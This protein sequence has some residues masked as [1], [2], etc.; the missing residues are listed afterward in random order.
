[1]ISIALAFITVIVILSSVLSLR[2]Q[3]N[4]NASLDIVQREIRVVL[5]IVDAINHTRTARTWL[6]QA[7]LLQGDAAAATA[8]ANA[9]DKLALSKASMERYMHI[10]KTDAEAQLVQDF[11]KNYDIYLAQGL[12]PLVDALRQGDATTYDKVLRFKTPVL[13]RQFEKSLDMVLQ[14]RERQS[15][16]LNDDIKAAFS[17]DM[18]LLLILAVGY[19]MAM[20]V[21]W[22]FSAKALAQPLNEMA[23]ALKRFANK[24]F[25]HPA[26][27]LPS[28]APIEIHTMRSSL[29]SMQVELSKT[30]G[31]IRETADTV[32]I[33]AAEISQGTQDLAQRTEQQAHQLQSS[34]ATLHEMSDQIRATSSDA[35]GVLQA[36]R[37]AVE[38]ACE[39]EERVKRVVQTM[40]SIQDA[41]QRIGVIVSTIDSIAFQTNILALNA[42]VEAARAGEQGR[43]FAVVASE[44]RTLAHRSAEAAKQI[45]ALI[46][47]TVSRI[48]AGATH[49]SEAGRIMQ[50][51]ME[52]VQS[53]SQL[54]ANVKSAIAGQSEEIA[55]VTS[56][57]ARMDATTQQNAAMVEENAAASESLKA[58]SVTLA[59][60]TAAFIT[61]PNAPQATQPSHRLR[62]VA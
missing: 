33:A 55:T 53:A 57:M 10:P 21:L 54:M 44:V 46:T 12:L 56:V 23:G 60:S 51:I 22:Y 48:D 40:A 43:G 11:K 59:E 47:D 34:A 9:Q 17:S 49:A 62:R 1:M 24:N 27:E 41:S 13:D 6:A 37:E 39:G 18:A 35:A 32:R 7:S 28:Y 25:A 16:T 19:V 36:S 26:A 3:L 5:D 38:V 58:L 29:G 42:A 45:N 50:A 2:A 31:S 30:I 20:G 4:S 61:L 52:K 14:Y 8:L 15:R